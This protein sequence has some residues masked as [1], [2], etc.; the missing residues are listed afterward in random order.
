MRSAIVPILS[1]CCC[2]EGF[3]IRPARHRAVVVHDL[4][5]HRGRVE[6]RETREIASRLGVSRAR[7]HAAGLRH[8]RKDVPGLAQIFGPRVRLHGG[9][10]GVRTIVRGDARGD[11][12]GRFD[13]QRE[14]GAMFAMRLAHHE[15]QAQLAAA[16]GG[17]READ[18]AA[19]ETRHEV[20]VFGAHLL[21]GHDE[22]AFVLAILVV[23]DHH[24]APGGDVG[25]NF[26]DAVQRLHLLVH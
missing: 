18:E 11:A 19:P 12:F 6:P 7:Q 24:H 25:E 23:H 26:F 15:R 17:Q 22:I 8:H 14:V 5:D 10:D 20:D 2:G 16:F 21:R 1:L 3:E 13:G 9:D 4:D